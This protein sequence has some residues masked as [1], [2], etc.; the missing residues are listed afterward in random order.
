MRK[1]LVR[2]YRYH[3]YPASDLRSGLA[4]VTIAALLFS[5]LSVPFVRADDDA[6]EADD[7]KVDTQKVDDLTAAKKKKRAKQLYELAKKLYASEEFVPA[8][9]AFAES[10]ALV[11]LPGALFNQGRCYEEA[12]DNK[13]AASA[14]RRYL[15]VEH[16]SDAT[17]EAK[18][19]LLALERLIRNNEKDSKG[20]QGGPGDQGSA[21]VK[22]TPSKKGQFSQKIGAAIGVAGAV[23]VAAGGLVG[24]KSRS[25]ASE[26][27]GRPSNQWTPAEIERFNDGQATSDRAV[28]LI[29]VGGVAVVTGAVLYV[30]GRRAEGPAVD[31][32][33]LVTSDG[34][35]VSASFRF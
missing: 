23:L 16:N 1:P 18:I 31:I 13:L 9:K 35:Q 22:D 21:V 26:F 30:F 25:I 2:Q 7:Q 3:R 8:A 19:R 10:Y 12:G 11:P 32:V 5:V 29:S 6:P 4:A 33:P 14:Y 15:E 24:L 34:A 28:F 17:T 27:D 20:G